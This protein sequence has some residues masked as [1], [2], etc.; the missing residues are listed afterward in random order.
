MSESRA[1]AE[2]Q[3]R[4]ALPKAPAAVWV[5]AL[6]RADQLGGL[7][8]IEHAADRAAAGLIRKLYRYLGPG[9]QADLPRAFRLTRSGLVDGEIPLVGS[10][11]RITRSI[12]QE[13]RQ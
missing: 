11:P 7:S 1:E 8:G 10:A 13:T 5:L 12:E 3:R 9:H 2:A 4:A 6:N